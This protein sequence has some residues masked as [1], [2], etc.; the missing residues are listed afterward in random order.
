[1]DLLLE[2]ARF[3]T[4]AAALQLFGVATF[5]A[6]LA[7][8][9]LRTALEPR[10]WPTTLASTLVLIAGQVMWLAA[11]AGTM[12]DGWTSA[13]DLTTLWSVLTATSFG[14]SWGPLLMLSALLLIIAIVRRHNWGILAILSGAV[15][16]GL[17]TIG[18]ATIG[19]GLAS[20]VNRISQAAHLLSS[21]FWVG[22]LL[23]L[24]FCIRLFDR[25]Y[26]D[27]DRAL[28]HFSGLGHLAVAALLLSGVANTWFVLDGPTIDLSR[29]YQGL[30]LAKVAIAGVMVCL[31]V[32]NRY[33][34]VPRIPNHGTGLVQ[35]A[36]G[37][38]AE[39]VLSAGILGLV[40]VIGTMSPT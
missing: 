32:V 3:V 1:L 5:Q 33:V 13:F 17:G 18:H 40:S 16:V 35:L 7:P 39:I 12:A 25:H 20:L 23:P 15:L 22:S 4:Y 26:A 8:A 10:A 38:I 37:T 6:V 9:A 14:R 36:H 34:F 31:A 11:T 24:L 21:G 2:A 28:R 30:L 29:P 27:A 19:S